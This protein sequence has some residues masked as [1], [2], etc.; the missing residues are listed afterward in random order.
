VF[1]PADVTIVKL[2][3]A[4]SPSVVWAPLA[5][6]AQAPA[7]ADEVSEQAPS[8]EEDGE[9]DRQQSE[10]EQSA[11]DW[12]VAASSSATRGN[13]THTATSLVSVGAYC[14]GSEQ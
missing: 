6:K 11:D 1:R 12:W 10:G 2:D 8:A 4:S 9:G 7:E 14:F 3:E 5:P 13:V